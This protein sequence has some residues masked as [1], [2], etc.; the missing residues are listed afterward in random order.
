MVVLGLT[1]FVLF[2]VSA[3]VLAL[4]QT[5]NVLDTVLRAAW[6]SLDIKQKMDIQDRFNCC[7]F[8]NDSVPLIDP[9]N[10][11]QCHPRK[12][13]G[14]PLCNTP[15]LMKVSLSV[16][17]T[18]VADNHVDLSGFIWRGRTLNF[19]PPESWTHFVLQCTY[20]FPSPEF[21]FPACNPH[22]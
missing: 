10:D 21:G 20:S 15:F 17:D 6:K 22:D 3:A 19:P 12:P 4:P 7:G 13:V 11:T 9:D 1:G 5:T 14:H 8:E 16:P 2:A 18:H